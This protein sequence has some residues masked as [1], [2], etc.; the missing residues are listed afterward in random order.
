MENFSR[1]PFSAQERLEENKYWQIRWDTDK[2]V[3][4]FDAEDMR[5]YCIDKI[6]GTSEADGGYALMLRARQKAIWEA[7]LAIFCFTYKTIWDKNFL[8]GIKFYL[9]R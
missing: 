2:K 7:R 5:K 3:T 9:Q 8:T 6:N 4:D 1:S